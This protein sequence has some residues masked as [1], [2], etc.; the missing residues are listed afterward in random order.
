LTGDAP[1]W[2]VIR[3]FFYKGYSILSPILKNEK[4][5]CSAAIDSFAAFGLFQAHGQKRIR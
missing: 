4:N 2:N 1:L 3:S 5:T